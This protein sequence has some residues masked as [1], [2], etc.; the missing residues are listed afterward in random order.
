VSP[1][2]YDFMQR[3]LVAAAL[4]GVAAPTVGIYLV[5]R[6]LSLMGDGIG[7]AVFA[8]LAAGLLTGAAPLAGALVAA[9]AAAVAIELLRE[10]GRTA[11]DVALALIFYGGIAG[12]ALLT[13]LAGASARIPSLLFGSLL[14]VS[15]ADLVEIAIVVLIAM[16]VSIGLRKQLFAAG[17]DEDAARVSGLP[18]RTLNLAV[19]LAAALTVV[20]AMRVVGVLLVSALLVLPVAAA[21]R[22]AGS[23]RA[24]QLGGA[25]IGL[26]VT[27]G[28]LVAAFYADLAPG[29][30]I[31]CA[32]ILAYGV[33]SA[34]GLARRAGP[35]R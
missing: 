23:F 9:C 12:G 21:G 27:V 8:G 3:A 2:S 28:G 7:H 29:A 14:A 24:T 22:V 25:A 30:T 33:A 15:T 13:Y 35:A 4:V 11:G 16:S 31:V 5:Q 34:A 26:L 17:Y 18:V 32:G 6:R 20:G 10:R 19:A 1:L